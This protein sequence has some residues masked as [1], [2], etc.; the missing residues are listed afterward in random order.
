MRKNIF[1][2]ESEHNFAEA[3]YNFC[4]NLSSSERALLVLDE[5]VCWRRSVFDDVDN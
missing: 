1:N 4:I 2:N 5:I 3:N